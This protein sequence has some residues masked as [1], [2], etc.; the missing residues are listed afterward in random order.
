MLLITWSKLALF[1]T[2]TLIY[3]TMPFFQFL[4]SL[5]KYLKVFPHLAIIASILIL[6]ILSLY[7][8]P[9]LIV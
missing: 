8:F 9:S 4:G 3:S 5:H 7:Y 6:L 2:I 1:P